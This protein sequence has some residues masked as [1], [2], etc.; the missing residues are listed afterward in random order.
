MVEEAEIDA[1]VAE[2]AATAA[3]GELEIATWVRVAVRVMRLSGGHESGRS[4]VGFFA[5]GRAASF[6]FLPCWR[7]AE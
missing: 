1:G 5:S 4:F 6:G 7:L 2:H 3:V